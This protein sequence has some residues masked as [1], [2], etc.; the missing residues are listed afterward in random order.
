MAGSL[1]Y[2]RCQTAALS[3]TAVGGPSRIVTR[4][5]R[6]SK[7]GLGAEQRE[8]VGTHQTDAELF[9]V[10]LA[11]ERGGGRPDGAET[12][13]AGA[14]L[15]EIQQLRTRQRRAG[16]ALRGLVGPDEDE[17]G[18]VAERQRLDEQRVGDAEDGRVGADAERERQQARPA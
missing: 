12:V 7:G 18:W 16:I 17:T 3:S 2:R 6:A 9:R 13:E 11:G 8:E 5:E 1:P 14:A 4:F 15:V 10:G